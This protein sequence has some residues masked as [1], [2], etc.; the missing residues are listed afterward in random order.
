MKILCPHC[1]N[2]SDAA[3]HGKCPLCKGDLFS[4][5][6]PKNI[7][8]TKETSNDIKNEQGKKNL[9]TNHTNDAED[10]RAGVNKDTKTRSMFFL[11]L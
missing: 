6:E 9:E 11:S 7:E 1:N 5:V 4:D 8:E 10:K 2:W 3:P